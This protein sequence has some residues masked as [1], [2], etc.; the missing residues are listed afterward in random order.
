MDDTIIEKATSKEEQWRERISEHRLSGLSV[1]Q[2][3]QQRGLSEYSFY[4]WRKR[5]RE[6]D[7]PVA[8][9]VGGARR[10]GTAARRDRGMPGIGAG[11]R[12]APTHQRG[13]GQ[14]DPTH[15]DGSLARMIHL[16]SSVQVYLCL[17]ACDMRKSFDGLHALV[18]Q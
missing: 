4:K 18:G 9:R 16:P 11:Q 1:G 2:F 6:Q 14:H 7:E 17:T 13:G 12:R 15:G 5:L 8:F 10:D 3:C